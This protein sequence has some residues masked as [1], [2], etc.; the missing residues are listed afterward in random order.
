MK[1]NQNAPITASGTTELAADAGTVWNVLADINHWPDWNPD[2]EWAVMEGGLAEGKTFRWKSGPG[3][4]TSTLR[5]IEPLRAMG[6]IGTTLGIKAVHVW[7]LT[8]Q[9]DKTVVTTQE[10][11][12]GLPARIFRGSMQKTLENAIQ[13]GLQHL[14]NEVERN[15]AT[16]T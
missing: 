16:E 9:D 2:I 13:T 6:W 11:W 8:S 5:Q 4:I 1:I 7:Q 15:V 14:K 3:V 12:D 10:S